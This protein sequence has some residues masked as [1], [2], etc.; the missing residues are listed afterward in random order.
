MG[1]AIPMARPP[2]P[3]DNGDVK[4]CVGIDSTGGAL[5]RVCKI[6][7][8]VVSSQ[9]V[10][11]GS[12]ELLSSHEAHGVITV[13]RRVVTAIAGEG[14]LQEDR[15]LSLRENPKYLFYFFTLG[16]STVLCRGV[17]KKICMEGGK[18]A[19]ICT[20]AAHLNA[21]LHFAMKQEGHFSKALR[22]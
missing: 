7:M 2:E 19:V 10:L 12:S 6:G 1:A 11:A 5:L 9:Y 3:R 13:P 18:Q 16:L 21:L 4:V 20:V 22:T 8:L 14:M 17:P 15:G